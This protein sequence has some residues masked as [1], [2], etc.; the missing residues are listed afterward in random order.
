MFS[1][2][3]E[4]W[5]AAERRPLVEAVYPKASFVPTIELPEELRTPWV[6]H[7]AVVSLL[8]GRMPCLGPLSTA[9]I[10]G[11]LGL[12]NSQVSAALEALEGEGL[13]IRGR[14]T[15]ESH[16]GVEGNA[17]TA[18]FSDPQLEWC[19]RRLL[20]G[21]IAARWTDC[22]DRFSRLSRP[23]TSVFWWSI[24]ILRPASGSAAVGACAGVG[25]IAGLRVGCRPVGAARLAAR[26]EGYEP[27]WLDDLSMSGELVWGRLRPPRK[28]DEQGKSSAVITLAVPIA[29][30]G[31]SALGL[32]VACGSGH[33]DGGLCPHGGSAGIGSV[34]GRGAV[35]ARTASVTGLLPSQLDEALHELAALDW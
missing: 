13:V 8:R 24:S 29:T 20:R 6:S 7:E 31:P 16:V 19:D 28:D 10:G 4:G 5:I 3:N 34:G 32:A 1:D 35:P 30:G 9:E 15:A 17:A 18:R 23:I 33:D 11:Q 25:P 12:P 2:Q 21:F 26:V 22:G 14:F 27:R